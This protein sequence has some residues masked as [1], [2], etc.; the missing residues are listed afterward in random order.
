EWKRLHNTVV[1]YRPQRPFAVATALAKS[2]YWRTA[3]KYR[4]PYLAAFFTYKDKATG[5]HVT[6]PMHL[7]DTAAGKPIVEAEH[8][9]A[10]KGRAV[11]VQTCAICHSSKQP[12]G[13]TLSFSRDWAG[14]QTLAP[15]AAPKLTL[16]M[17]FT[18][19]T[20]FTKGAAYG[21]YVKEIA[22]LAGEAS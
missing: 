2:V 17:D 12:D 11:F 13:F 9:D 20:D 4:I 21:E 16:P 1:G 7:A 6:Q 3:D 5:E 18:D 14:K 8:G 15:G 22:A 10:V 19:W